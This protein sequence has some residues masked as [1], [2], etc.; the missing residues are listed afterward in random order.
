MKRIKS[1]WVVSGMLLLSIGLS[2]SVFADAT[3]ETQLKSAQTQI[4]Q[5]S[6]VWSN[7]DHADALADYF[8]VP[9]SA[10][11]QLCTKNQGW[12]AVTIELSMAWEL[13]TMHSRNFPF[14]T[15][16]LNRIESLR[17]EGNGWGDIASKLQFGLGPVV[18]EAQ[19]AA[20][21]LREDDLALTE[22]NEESARVAENRR[23]IR[24]EHQIAQANRADHR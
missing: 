19:D 23:I 13:N 14:M 6:A 12:G 9:V 15:A 16:A 4:D 3:E 8:K 1:S 22:K 11:Q 10:I 21:E 20:Q 2:R 18:R 17:A 24:E 5:H 7:E